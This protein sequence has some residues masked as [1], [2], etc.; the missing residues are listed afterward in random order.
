M[1]FCLGIRYI[2]LLGS[3]ESGNEAYANHYERGSYNPFCADAD[4]VQCKDDTRD[5]EDITDKENNEI[6]GHRSER[7]KR[8]IGWR[9]IRQRPALRGEALNVF[10]HHTSCI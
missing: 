4:N 3:G 9:A 6:G 5:E 1:T 8:N 2:S 10:N 7:L